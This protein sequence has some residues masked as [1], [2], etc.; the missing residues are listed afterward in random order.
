MTAITS[1]AVSAA[2]AGHPLYARLTGEFGYPLLTPDT[3][4]AFLAQPGRRLLVFLDDPGRV[5]ESLDLAVIAP[6]LAAEFAGRLQVGVLLA[7][8]AVAVARRFGFRRWPALVVTDG[9]G[10]VGAIDG[11][12]D[13]TDYVGELAR[14]LDAPVTRAPTVGIAVRAETAQRHD[15]HDGHDGHDHHCH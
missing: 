6:E 3:L 4:D 7:P 14:L 11:L 9:A 1:A 12:R 8:G 13:W 10:Y 2:A 5:R 15:S